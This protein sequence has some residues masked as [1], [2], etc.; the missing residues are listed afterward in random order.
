[1]KPSG[2]LDGSWLPPGWKF[3][4]VGAVLK[5]SQYGTNAPSSKRGNVALVG[6]GD[7]LDGKVNTRDLAL[8]DLKGTE[9][10]MYL[11][12]K[13]DLLFNRTNSYDL[14]GKVGIYESD[15]EAVFASYLVRLKADSGM[16]NPWFLNY[17]LNGQIAQRMIRR[18]ATRAIGQAN[19]NPTEFKKN[20]YVPVPPL[21]EQSRIVDLLMTWDAGIE[22]TQK[23]IDERLKAKQGLMQLVLTGKSRLKG[24]QST[25]HEWRMGDLFEERN[26]TGYER[27]PLLSI[28]REEGVIS[29]DDVER[30]DTSSEDK[31]GYRRICPGDIGYNTMRMWQ[32]VSALSSLEGIV[33]PAYTVCTPK[34]GVDG[35]FMSYLF[36]LPRTVNLFYRYSQGL[37]SDTWNLKYRHFCEIKLSI[38]V[39]EEQWAISNVLKACDEEI[40][41][42]RNRLEAIKMQKKG[43]MQ[44]V[45]TGE[46]RIGS[47]DEEG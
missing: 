3:L 35:R 24:F 5:R 39:I 6:M 22:S 36:K 44:K 12:E 42:L 37:T 10:Q 13:G 28:T 23:L 30:K 40:G 27:L 11:L 34:D 20:C 15:A 9:R 18:I 32:G 38:P 43:L 17:W 16:M 4:P 21:A 7:V 2:V 19:I 31:S 47:T 8:T 41:L 26:E 14:V 33:S 46:R 29:R 1:M 25:W 45:L